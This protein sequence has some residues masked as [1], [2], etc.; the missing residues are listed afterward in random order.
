MHAD[1]LRELAVGVPVSSSFGDEVTSGLVVVDDDQVAFSLAG[2][3]DVGQGESLIAWLVDDQG[4]ATSDSAVLARPGPLDD[5]LV[6]HVLEIGDASRLIVTREF[7][8]PGEAPEGEV[9]V[10]AD[11]APDTDP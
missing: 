3:A 2:V 11:L 6:A 4:V 9:L 1:T 5:G 7:T 8:P 10:E